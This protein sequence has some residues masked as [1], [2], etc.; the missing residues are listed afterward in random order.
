MGYWN[1]KRIATYATNSAWLLSDHLFVAVFNLFV[2]VIVARYL[3]PS[4]FG[5]LSYTFALAAIVGTFGRMGLDGLIVRELTENP[6][7][8]AVIL[9]TTFFLKLLAYTVSAISLAAFGYYFAQND[10]ERNLL[11]IAGLFLFLTPFLSVNSWFYAKIKGKSFAIA[12]T[13]GHIA[14]GVVKL[15]A[16]ASSLSILVFAIANTLQVATTAISATYLYLKQGGSRFSK[17]RFSSKVARRM[18]MEGWVIFLAAVLSV[19]YLKVDQVMLKWLTT[20]ETVGVYSVA[21]K[22]SEA[23]YFIPAALMA[24]VFPRLINLRE[25][26][27][28]KFNDG[29][30]AMF[31]VMSIVSLIIVL[32]I[33]LGAQFVV[34]I[35]FGQE[36]SSAS[37]VLMLHVIALPLIFVRTVFTRWILIERFP[38]FLLYSDGAGALTNVALNLLLIPHWGAMGAAFATIV[39]YSIAS[40]LMLA[41]HRRT[42]PLFGMITR[43]IFL[44]WR[45][46]AR[47][48]QELA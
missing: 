10:T 39:S 27:E 38:S 46:A 43:S 41:V 44:P 4:G 9:G 24:S 8:E 28:K 12:N 37:F 33:L 47:I 25:E 32:F 18:L 14:A 26:N 22:L 35:L 16:A 31:D 45:A 11:C 15:V 19:I 7:E 21:A 23:T 6:R 42:R 29:L 13:G 48:K 3:G 30:Q 20:P 40:Y 1:F 17:W 36:Y 2:T 5:V 34:P